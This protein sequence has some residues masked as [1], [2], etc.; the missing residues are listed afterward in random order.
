M[1]QRGL[2]AS[3]VSMDSNGFT[4]NTRTVD[5]EADTTNLDASGFTLNWTTNDA[6]ATEA[7]YLALGNKRRVMVV[8]SA[9]R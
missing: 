8:G 5:A 7:L 2:L 6:G 4:I 3:W 9:G 1:G